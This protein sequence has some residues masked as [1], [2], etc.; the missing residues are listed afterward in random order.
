MSTNPWDP[1]DVTMR[2]CRV[3][4]T[5]GK[6]AAVMALASDMCRELGLTV[7]LQDVDTPGRS[8]VLAMDPGEPAQVL[9]TT[10]LDTVPPYI[11]PVDAGDRLTGRGTCDAKGAAA[12]MFHAV[13]T[14]RQAGERRVGL[15]FLVGEEG[16]SDG[17]KAAARGWAPHVRYFINGEP[18]GNALAS[19]Q[20]GTLSFKLHAHGVACHSAYPELGHSALHTLT[21]TVHAMLHASWPTDAELGETTVNVGLLH[22]GVATNVLAPHAE[23][24]GIFRLAA[25]VATVEAQLRALLPQ[26]VTHERLGS[27]DPVRFH[28]P[29]GQP[30]LVVRFGSDVPYLKGIGVPL[31]LGPGS[32]HDAHTDHEHVLKADLIAAAGIYASLARTLLAS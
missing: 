15:M 14:L 32:I 23:A 10:H 3:E 22:G 27:T 4:S 21:D 1:V 29:D 20:K 7:S 13:H 25:P 12:A 18:T 16:I 2:L 6:E 17:A 9:L 24:Q 28:V 19:A 30:S 11:A 31:M 26:H 5:T 8:N